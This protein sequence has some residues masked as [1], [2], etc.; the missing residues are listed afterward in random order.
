M[1]TKSSQEGAVH[2]GSLKDEPPKRAWWYSIKEPG[3]ALQIVTAAL[4]SIAIGLVVTFTVDDVPES[5]STLVKIP[6][7]LWLRAL[8]AVGEWNQSNPSLVVVRSVWRDG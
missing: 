6:G 1:S 8:K 5:A 4:L 2:V 7:T 3:S